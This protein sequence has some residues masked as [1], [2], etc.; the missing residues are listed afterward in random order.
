MVIMMNTVWYTKYRNR[1]EFMAVFDTEQAYID[2]MFV[3]MIMFNFG[4]WL[5]TNELLSANM[6]ESL[7]L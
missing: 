6:K 1:P 2:A 5:D 7:G 3:Q 4:V